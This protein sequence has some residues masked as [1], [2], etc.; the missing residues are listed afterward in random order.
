MNPPGEGGKPGKQL[1]QYMENIYGDTIQFVEN[2]HGARILG[3]STGVHADVPR[4]SLD[5]RHRLFSSML[6]CSPTTEAIFFGSA[7]TVLRGV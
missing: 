3:N 1:M 2:S 4:I 6:P 5:P 7:T